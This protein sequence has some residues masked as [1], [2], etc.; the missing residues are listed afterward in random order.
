MFLL[1]NVLV[2]ADVEV[3]LSWAVLPA[4]TIAKATRRTFYIPIY[5]HFDVHRTTT[6]TVT[7]MPTPTRTTA[8]THT[9]PSSIPYALPQSILPRHTS[10]STDTH[11]LEW[12]N[13]K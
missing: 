2:D 4:P 5:C 12:E 11:I 10:D 8:Q 3:K 13:C 9:C 6:S 7:Y 1:D